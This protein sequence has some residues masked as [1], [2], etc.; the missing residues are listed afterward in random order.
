[1]DEMRQIVVINR[2]KSLPNSG[3]HLPGKT[4][5]TILKNPSHNSLLDMIQTGNL[6]NRS[7]KHNSLSLPGQCPFHTTNTK[8]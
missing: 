4:E 1:M 7:Q 2:W 6:L 8:V 3:W 5:K